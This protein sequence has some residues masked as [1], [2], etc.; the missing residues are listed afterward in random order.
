MFIFINSVK[1]NNYSLFYFLI[2]YDFFQFNNDL[3]EEKRWI[4]NIVLFRYQVKLDGI[5]SPLDSLRII[6]YES[7]IFSLVAFQIYYFF[8]VP[9]FR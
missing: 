2:Y 7:G 5:I 3:L 4:S 8:Q 9:L 6:F 1:L